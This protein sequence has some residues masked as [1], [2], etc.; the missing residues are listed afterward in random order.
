MTISSLGDHEPEPPIQPGP[1]AGLPTQACPPN[2]PDDGEKVGDCLTAEEIAELSREEWDLVAPD[3]DDPA[4][5]D[6]PQTGAPPEWLPLPPEDEPSQVPEMFDAGFTHSLGGNGSG[7]A[8][9][10]PLD[11][12]LPGSQLAMHLGQAAQQPLTRYSD[13]E[14]F[15]L[16]GATAREESWTVALKHTIVGEIDRRRAASDGSPGEHAEQELAAALTLTSWSASALLDLARDLRRLP[17]TRDLLAA[18]L[19]DPRR[20]A[21]IARHTAI[22]TDE[23]AAKAEDLILPRAAQMTTGELS[24]LCLRAVLKVD[25]HA[26]RKRKEK[27]LKDARVETW[28]EDS[29]TGAIAGRDLPP[30]EVI[31]AD[32]YIDAIARWLKANGA[33]GTLDELRAKV[34]LALLNGQPIES[35]LPDPSNPSSPEPS[36][37]C[38][39]EPA[40]PA[41]STGEAPSD[42]TGHDGA[43]PDSTSR[44]STTPDSTSQATATA[45]STDGRPASTTPDSTTPDGTSPAS[46]TPA[47]T[48]GRPASQPVLSG[49]VNLTMPYDTWQGLADNPGDIAGYGAADAGTCRDIATRL[50]ASTT[51]RWCITLTDRNGKPTAHG[52]ARAG[53]SPPDSGDPVSWLRTITIHPIE[54]VTCAH[55]KESAAYQP[56]SLLRHIIKVRSPRCGFPGCRRA[57]VRCDDDHTIPYHLG[58]R[59]CE[60][61]LYPLCRRHH[62]CKQAPGWHLDQP[63]PGELIWTSPSG[64]RYTKITEPYPV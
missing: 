12:L 5:D 44:A 28:L 42:G 21:V 23:N 52:C 49:T 54:T 51:T 50:A 10:G 8:A 14:L 64:R 41:R 53:P 15:G 46:A 26:A 40:E 2:W 38:S 56:S 7:F 45:A 31:A 3:P 59:S 18:G 48:D 37:P 1:D 55:L 61:N 6:D 17:K 34:Y 11:V 36:N 60:C 19:I 62:Q 58:G 33:E 29:G 39:P 9:G 25:P 16:L 32:K 47:S 4:Y 35:L 63:R 22:L 24:S 13:D 43:T 20:A 30:A 27:A 57:A